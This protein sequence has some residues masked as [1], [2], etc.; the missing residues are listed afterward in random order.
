M[1]EDCN[2]PFLTL[3]ELRHTY[4]TVLREKGVDIYSISKLLGHASIEVTA[5]IYVHNDLEVLRS[6]I[7]GKDF[8]TYLTP[9]S[10]EK[11]REIPTAK[12]TG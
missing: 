12:K 9:K 6:A 10:T 8:D 3:H 11:Y 2:L 4:G 1:A 7:E 5:K